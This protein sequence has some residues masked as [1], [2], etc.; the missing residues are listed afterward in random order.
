MLKKSFIPLMVILLSLFIAGQSYAAA[1]PKNLGHVQDRAG[2]FKEEDK[3]ELRK[4]AIGRGLNFY[5]LTIPTFDG[6]DSAD[7]ATAVY[8][9][10]SLTKKDVLLVIADKERRIEV[11]FNNPDLQKKID[12]LKADYDNDGNRTEAK[13]VELVDKHFIPSAK[14]GDFL[15]AV[16]SLMTTIDSF[17][18]APVSTKEPKQETAPVV[19]KPVNKE[20]TVPFDWSGFFSKVGSVAL[21]VLIAVVIVGAIVLLVM[22]LIKGLLLKRKLAAIRERV[23]L[24]LVDISQTLEAVTP[25]TDLS[26]GKTGSLAKKKDDSLTE[27]LV[28]TEELGKEMD[29]LRIFILKL[30]TLRSEIQYYTEIADENEQKIKSQTQAADE[31]VNAERGITP[32]IEEI[33]LAIVQVESGLTELAGKLGNSFHTFIKQLDSSKINLANAEKQ[34]AFDPMSAME[35]AHKA[36]R[37]CAAVTS[38]YEELVYFS[39]KCEGY[40]AQERECRQSIEGMITEH[41]LQGSNQDYY[42]RLDQSST[43][44]KQLQSELRL[45][46]IAALRPLWEKAEQ[47]LNDSVNNMNRMIDLRRSNQDKAASLESKIQQLHHVQEELDD[48][49]MRV[50]EQYIKSLW[51]GLK[52]EFDEFVTQ[53]SQAR[54]Q[55]EKAKQDDTLQKFEQ[56]KDVFDDLAEDLSELELGARHCLQTI[57]QWDLTLENVKEQF[58]NNSALYTQTLNHM[59]TEAIIIPADNLTQAAEALVEQVKA[60]QQVEQSLP[61]NLILLE[62]HG[63]L[64]QD[65]IAKFIAMVQGFEQLKNSTVQRLQTCDNRYQMELSMASGMFYKR[66][67]KKSYEELRKQVVACLQQGQYQDALG[68]LVQL[69]QI[70]VSLIGTNQVKA[71]KIQRRQEQAAALFSS[72]STTVH[73]KHTHEHRHSGRNRSSSGSSFWGSGGGSSSS[74]SNSSSSSSS[75]TSSKSSSSSGSS[76]GSSSSSSK[77]SSGGSSFKKDGGGGGNSSG[78]SNW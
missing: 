78:G 49:F 19:K 47:L 71:E 52:A 58:V 22:N 55:L 32:F 39:D 60:Y 17:I 75:S 4:E 65:T 46:N 16:R 48:E 61:C 29:G 20:P 69:E 50:S 12:K 3:K 77:N 70:V 18:P 7:Y 76:W 54:T 1:L 62:Q 24:Q 63:D 53:F 11:N 6:Q 21:K 67:I 42:A 51:G 23:A 15:S 66:K 43:I 37:S 41:N 2:Y 59:K 34:A 8:E 33:R 14:E 73:H 36:K 31:L 26:Q 68:W 35:E 44:I 27:L 10:W 28:D 74:S 57:E 40:P 56:A 38:S 45:G 13:L 72:R 64:Y 25:L 5:I 30:N 9:S